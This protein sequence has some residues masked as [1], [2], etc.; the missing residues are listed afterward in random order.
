MTGPDDGHP[1]PG[2]ELW[3]RPYT[4]TN[5]RTSPSTALD[6]ISLVQATGRGVTAAEWLGREHTQALQLCHSMTSVAE[7]A[8]LLRQPVLITK[9]LLADLIEWGALTARRPTTVDSSNPARLK[10]LLDGLRSL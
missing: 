3:E 4:V 7:V 8:A 9:I 10:D 1:E 2:A 5:G 6:L